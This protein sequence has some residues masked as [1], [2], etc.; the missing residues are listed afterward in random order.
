MRKTT[1]NHIVRAAL[2]YCIGAIS[3]VLV[4]YSPQ[5]E[6]IRLVLVIALIILSVVSGAILERH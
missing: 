4:L 1:E 6:F 5:H 2:G 3:M